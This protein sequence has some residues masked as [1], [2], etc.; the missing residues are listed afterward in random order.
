MSKNKTK[1][2]RLGKARGLGVQTMNHI[3]KL[4]EDEKLIII[5]KT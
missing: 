4:E 2:L 3:N 5:F 1:K